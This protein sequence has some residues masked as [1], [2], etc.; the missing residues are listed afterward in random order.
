MLEF[1]PKEIV[2]GLAQAQT[3]LLKRRARLRVHV[4]D[5]IYPVLRY[6]EG[7]FSLDAAQVS[8]LRGLVDLHD[9]GR[10]VFQCLIVASA[11]EQGELIC[12]FKRSTAVA[13][14]P[15]RDYWLGE[16]APVALL[17]RA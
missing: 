11:V 12:E 4:G 16:H 3:R 13:D 14:R 2:E 10:H 15:P 8:H 6:W 1:L 17:P 7:G 5:A 9:G